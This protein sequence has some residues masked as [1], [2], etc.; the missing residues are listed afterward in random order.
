M[1]VCSHGT[2]HIGEL[3]AGLLKRQESGKPAFPALTRA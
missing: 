3:H 2:D 1:Q